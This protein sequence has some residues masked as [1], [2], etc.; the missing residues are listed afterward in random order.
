MEAAA[1]FCALTFACLRLDKRVR[2]DG[3]MDKA[4]AVADLKAVVLK[5]GG[6]TQSRRFE[7]VSGISDVSTSQS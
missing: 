1:L 7:S 2:M 3:Q 5:A 4:F 6:C